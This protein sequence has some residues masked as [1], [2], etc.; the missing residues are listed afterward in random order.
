[1]SFVYIHTFTNCGCK[2]IYNISQIKVF[3]IFIYNLESFFLILRTTPREDLQFCV[4]NLQC[5]ILLNLKYVE[6][7]KTKFLHHIVHSKYRIVKC[8]FFHGHCQPKYNEGW[9]PKPI[10]LEPSPYAIIYP[11]HPES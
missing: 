9:S 4:Y 2:K 1:M 10:A 6:D 3:N 7:W 8:K 11:E 5:T